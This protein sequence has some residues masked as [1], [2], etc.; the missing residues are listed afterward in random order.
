MP[1][2][3]L[4]DTQLQSYGCYAG[5]PTQAQLSRYFYLADT[6][7]EMIKEHR[8]YHNRLGFA[9]Q[10]CT[11]RFLGTLLPDPIDVPV[12]VIAT[13]A[14]QLGISEEI[15]LEGYRTGK[16]KWIH[17][18]EIRQMCGYLD[19]NDQPGHF[20][21]VRWLYLRAWLSAERPSVLF[22]L[23]TARLVEN[24]VLLPGA[25]VLARLVAS[26]RDR[27]AARLWRMLTVIPDSSCRKKLENLL[28]VPPEERQTTFDRLRRAPTRISAPAIVDALVRLNDVRELGLEK[29]DIGGIPPNRLR[30]LARYASGAKAQ[31][32][33]RM[34]DDRRVATLVAFVFVL[35]TTAQDDVIDM[36]EQVLVRMFARTERAGQQERLRTIGDYDEAVFRL[37]TA[38]LALLD[39]SRLDAAAKLVAVFNAVSEKDLEE[40]VATVNTLTRPSQ[41]NYHEGLLSHYSLVR[42]FFPA[43][44]RTLTFEGT[45]TGQPI[46]ESLKFLASIEGQRNPSLHE[47]PLDVVPPSWR[48]LVID[49]QEKIDRRYYTFCVLDQLQEALRRRDVFVKHSDR[50]G[51]PRRKLL[52]GDEWEAA[53]PR[54]CRV[55]EKDPDA[56][57]ELAM[58]EQQL[59]EAYRRTAAN[60]PSNTSVRLEKTKGRDSLVLT[61][62][63][64]QDEPPSLISLRESINKRLPLV[65]L[66]EA[67]LEVDA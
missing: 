19:F 27:A 7:Q 39:P 48:G 11:A 8:G 4:T 2:E 17:A 59:A 53:K 3:F 58:L 1:V 20:R 24:K 60:L 13:L 9:L 46:L 57:R 28:I 54:L 55:L 40:A 30:T 36:L 50:W 52:Q 31:T 66:P 6:D 14:S 41:E 18:N 33:S 47:A 32:I 25:S 62:L 44:L 56:R 61:G 12:V 10:L 35:K 42:R 65:D 51:D 38:C 26:V 15:E 29:M 49:D 64:K 21:F 37:R 23:A 5:P 43:L 45:E 22:D 34:Q 63:E 67:V 16:T